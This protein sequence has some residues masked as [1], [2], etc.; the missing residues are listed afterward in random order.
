MTNTVSAIGNRTEEV[1]R[2]QA[3]VRRGDELVIFYTV[4]IE[5]YD[6]TPC[7]YSLYPQH[8]VADEAPRWGVVDLH[9]SWIDLGEQ[10]GTAWDGS[11]KVQFLSMRE[12]PQ[13]KINSGEHDQVPLSSVDWYHVKGKDPSGIEANQWRARQIR[14]CVQEFPYCV[15]LPYG[16]VSGDDFFVVSRSDASEV[17]FKFIRVLPVSYSVGWS[18]PVHVALYPLAIA[19][20]LATFPVQLPLLY[21]FLCM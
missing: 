5:S 7:H 4:R 18:T 3:A 16:S 14:Q 15:N 19:L 1:R 10:L 9:S 8:T 21:G 11:G 2:Y 13:P 12:G 20:D 6:P 17:R